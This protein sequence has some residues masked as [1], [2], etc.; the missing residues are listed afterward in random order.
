[1]PSIAGT[2]SFLLLFVLI[3][4]VTVHEF[5]HAKSADSAGDPTPR[6][7]GRVTLNPLA[8]LDPWGTLFMVVMAFSGYGLGWGKPVQV[9]PQLMQ[10]PRWDHFLSVAWG[11]LSNLII[12]VIFALV[13]R[14]LVPFTGSDFLG[15]ACM[16]VVFVNL[17]LFFFN[18]IP[19]GPLDGH[20]L[21]GAIL[22]PSLAIPYLRWCHRSGGAVLL[23]I[24]LL[25]QL[26][27]R[28]TIGFGIL[29][30]VVWLP[31]MTVAKYLLGG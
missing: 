9:N 24:L 21:V 19:I 29:S 28:H 17:A 25:D 13:F 2:E 3:F 14:F 16:F 22:P 31:A 26:I 12:A 30:V 27:L 15:W 20:W 18:L 4:S 23:G 6:S 1:M 10:N 11:P 5:A 8:H 7:Q